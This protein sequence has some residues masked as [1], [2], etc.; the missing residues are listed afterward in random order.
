MWAVSLCS[1]IIAHIFVPL[2]GALGFRKK[3]LKTKAVYIS[4][5][6]IVAYSIFSYFAPEYIAD[7]VLRLHETREQSQVVYEELIKVI[8][9][10]DE[11]LTEDM[12][13]SLVT[14]KLNSE[15]ARMDDTYALVD[16]LKS[17]TFILFGL[18]LIHISVLVNALRSS[19]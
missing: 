11:P 12:A 14:E 2:S 6:L 10:A 9:E 3:I 18:L 15:T 1:S 5:S 16:L 8:Q 13:I 19:K 7:N 4:F 17:K